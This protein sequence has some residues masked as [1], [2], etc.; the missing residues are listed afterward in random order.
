MICNIG[1]QS[2]TLRGRREN[3]LAIIGYDGCVYGM[4]NYGT[5]WG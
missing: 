3:Y 4:R 5:E 2:V 1:N